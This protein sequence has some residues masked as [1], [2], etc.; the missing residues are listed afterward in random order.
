M[1]PPAEKTSFWQILGDIEVNEEGWGASFARSLRARAA[2]N[3]LG[4]VWEILS[5]PAASVPAGDPC[6]VPKSRLSS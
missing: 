4:C 1:R 5:V 3:S 6:A 2:S